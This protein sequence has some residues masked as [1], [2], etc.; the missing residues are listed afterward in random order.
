MYIDISKDV[1]K[2]TL[3]NDWMGSNVVLETSV[4]FMKELIENPINDIEELKRR[5]NAIHTPDLKYPLEYIRDTEEDVSWGLSLSTKGKDDTD[6]MMMA[7]LFPSEFYNSWL[8]YI[9]PVLELYHGYKIYSL[10]IISLI[11]PVSIVVAPYIYLTK[12]LKFQISLKKYLKMLWDILKTSFNTAGEL[13][14]VI[15]KWITFGIYIGVYLYS[16]Y[17]T[18]DLSM[19]LHNFRES[20]FKRMNG[21]A[22][23]TRT[24]H[25]IIRNTDSACWSPFCKSSY[26]P[27]FKI[28]GN[29]SDA[30]C[31]WTNAWSYRERLENLLNCI[32]AIDISNTVSRLYHNQHWCLVNYSRE[33]SLRFLGMRNPLLSDRQ[34]S[35]PALLEKNIIMTGPNAAGKTTYVKSIVL[36]AVLAQ[37]VGIAMCNQAILKPFDIIST[38]MR[39]HDI[40]GKRSFYEAETEYCKSMLD[41]AEQFADKNTLF[42]MDEPMHSTPPT[43]GFA[44]AY[45]VCKYLGTR[46]ANC[47]LIITTHY[48]DM[49]HLQTDYPESFINLSVEALELPNSAFH[50]PYKVKNRYSFQCI[51]IE[52]LDT[53][54]FPKEVVDTAIKIKNKISD[55]QLNK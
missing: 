28:E 3:I 38:F 36:N 41:K 7:M 25:E 49:V 9:N 22:T 6:R 12:S 15:T 5:Q 32:V 37:T 44:T 48:H 26:D 51:A 27:E 1:F 21:I 54:V 39:V 10:P 20:L 16:I 34:I 31:L 24:A 18:F 45:A 47:K 14:V 46:Y 4:P 33:T 29:L 50:F 35:N 40:V 53:K 17:Q 52:L 30:Y 11:N 13:K 19:S 43:E 55:I 42:V 2:D 23:F 8:S